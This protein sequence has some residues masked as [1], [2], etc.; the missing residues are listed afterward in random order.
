MGDE[1]EEGLDEDEEDEE[2]GGMDQMDAGGEEQEHHDHGEETEEGDYDEDM[3]EEDYDGEMGAD[4]PPEMPGSN[5]LA[6]VLQ[7]AVQLFDL[8]QEGMNNENMTFRVDIDLGE[9]GVIHGV[10][11]GGQFRRMALP[12]PAGSGLRGAGSLQGAAP[13]AGGWTEPG[14]LDS[15][16]EHPLLRRDPPPPQQV[17]SD[18][19]SNRMMQWM[20]AG[21]LHRYLG[22]EIGSSRGGNASASGGGAGA[23][24]MR[25]GFETIFSDLSGRLQEQLRTAAVPAPPPPPPLELQAEPD[26]A[27][28]GTARGETSSEQTSLAGSGAVAEPP[29]AGG[30]PSAEQGAA[31]NADEPMPA[32]P[33]VAVSKWSMPG[34][35]APATAA[36]AGSDLAAPAPAALVPAAPA[37]AALV[38][39]APAPIAS[40]PAVAAP[41]ASAP[42][43]PARASP[44]PAAPVPAD[45]V[46]VASAPTVP[47]PAAPV[48]A[49][50][51]PA[52]AVPAG[53]TGAAATAQDAPAAD[54]PFADAIAAMLSAITPASRP[55]PAATPPPVAPNPA[56]AP[57]AE[58]IAELAAA[59]APA[60]A[61]ESA[62]PSAPEAPS[63]EE[64]AAAML[65]IE[66]LQRLS[67]RLGCRQ[68]E[69]LQA[70]GIDIEVVAAL[71]E[72]IRGPVVMAEVS[73][74]NLDHLRR[75]Q[76]ASTGGAAEAAAPENQAEDTAGSS[77]IDAVVLEALPPD[78]REEVLREEAARR[79]E[80]QQAAAAAEAAA[81][82]GDTQSS[83]IDNASFIA[84]L[85][86]VLREEVLLSAP[87]ELL[88]TLPAELVAEAQLIR[89]RAFTRIAMRREVPPPAAMQRAAVGA[90]SAGSAGTQASGAGTSAARAWPRQHAQLL[91]IEQQLLHQSAGT[92]NRRW[93]PGIGMPRFR[94]YNGGEQGQ[95]SATGLA[96]LSSFDESDEQLLSRL[97]DFDEGT[98][99][100]LALPLTIIPSVCRLLYLRQ[101]VATMPMTRLCFNLSLHP[102]SRSCILGHFLVLLCR[103]SEASAALDVLPPPCLFESLEGRA[104][105]QCSPQEVEAVGSQRVLAILAYF[106]RRLPQCGEFF[107]HKLKH[108]PWM[109]SL[110]SARWTG[111]DRSKKSKGDSLLTEDVSS[112]DLP[113]Q[114][115]VNLLMQLVTTKLYLSSSRHATWLLSVLHALLVPPSSKDKAAS[116]TGSAAARALGPSAPPSSSPSGAGDVEMAQATSDSA[117]GPAA[118]APGS[119]RW[120]KITEEMHASLSQKSVLALCNFLCQAGSGYSSSSEGDAF[121]LA[122]DILVAL[123]ASCTH[124]DMVRAELMQV[125]ATL[126]TDIE[127]ALAHCEPA[128]AEPS[129][130]ESR[131]LRVVRTLTEVFRQASKS[132]QGQDRKPE[133]FMEEARV[134]MLWGALDRTLERLDDTEVT[135]TPA[136]R[137]LSSA[138]GLEVPDSR[139]PDERSAALSSQTAPPKPLLNRLLPLIEAFFVLHGHDIVDTPPE[140]AKKEENREQDGETKLAGATEGSSSSSSSKVPSKSQV[141]AEMH[142]LSAA[143]RSRFG[144][145]CK[146]HRRPLNALVKQTPSLLSKSFAPVLHLM[147]SCLDFDNKRAYFRSQ[148]RSRRLESRYET[149]RLRVRR[150]EIFMD[151]YHQLRVRTGEEMRAKIQVQFQGEEGIDAGGVA[152]EWYGALA[153]E[154]F[155]PNYALFVQAGGKACTYHPNP[156][157][158]VNRDHLQFFHFIGRVI[159]KAIHDGQNLEAWFTRG[160]YKH[161]LGRKV[162]PADLEAFDPE[163][164]SNLKWMLDHDI[165]DIIELNFSAESDELGKMKVVDLK[166]DGRTL[167]VTNDNKH[168]Y[169]QLMSEHKMTNSVRQQIEH[170]LKGLHEIVP[171]QLLSLFDDKELEL[172]ISGLPDIDIEDLKQNTEYHNYTPQS[173]QVVWFWKVLSDFSQEQ[174]A[175][176]LQF[177]TGTSR[178]PVEGFKGLIGMR[179]PQK[180]SLHRAYGADRLPSAHTCFNQVDL[181]DYPSEEVL[182][183]KLLQAVSEGHEGFGFA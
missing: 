180:F 147:P 34:A 73:Q 31:G 157:S 146:K 46:P 143:E 19:E 156:M 164:F 52:P 92:G 2:G 112:G 140:A 136:Q 70:A 15:P 78:I 134:E 54:R 24:V 4:L 96:G 110:Q 95:G 59:F 79:R 17:G 155:N 158:Y 141:F 137:L 166:P 66:E 109:Q 10:H 105:P 121:Q 167:P 124:L 72:D 42:A 118:E 162:I 33:A 181:P 30:E 174:R 51:A 40:A 154:I 129:T 47:P 90:P 55:A 117:P 35:L 18:Q 165:T 131:F 8:D 75:P 145:F 60:P 89:D 133:G 123:A 149:I 53:S 22:A 67:T 138:P 68:A 139:A 56:A 74:V 58:A 28:M 170:F 25:E 50:P 14:D 44:A 71:P 13:G 150:N 37:P 183:E 153:K 9:A 100:E 99:A 76:Q 103:R 114:C 82:R 144:Q 171:P 182:R 7:N 152:K 88:R 29:S 48:A 80:Q 128:A 91:A 20:P 38:P 84:S 135:A 77:E 83:E 176:F 108:E 178:V 130:M 102:A 125:L 61:A 106:L 119:T 132:K 104:A 101:E 49:A 12:P 120:A 16:A 93:G 11:R 21:S 27:G 175:W 39:A 1:G 168:E 177:A 23:A 69:I 160:F 115:P 5:N 94:L 113:G 151:S 142:E 43:A 87:E 172:L 36:L 41:I 169:I 62:A 107:A 32:A 65:G 3:D 64:D 45:P 179:G 127:K 97:P 159:G 6:S 98:S 126:V 57:S 86:P 163:Y 161:M 85:D 111:E 63:Q 173:E 26:A 81:A 116:S 122:G 148:L